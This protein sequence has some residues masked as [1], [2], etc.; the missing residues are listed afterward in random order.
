VQPVDLRE[1]GASQSHGSGVTAGMAT[2]ARMLW[3]PRWGLPLSPSAL[4]RLRTDPSDIDVAM[5]YKNFTPV[6][7]MQPAAKLSR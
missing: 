6:V 2:S 7:L 3:K 4:G 5:I 1:G